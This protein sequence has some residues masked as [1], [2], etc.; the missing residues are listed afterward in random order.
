MPTVQYPPEVIQA[1]NYITA[2]DHTVGAGLKG[3]VDQ[4]LSSNKDKP[5]NSLWS[6]PVSINAYNFFLTLAKQ[7]YPAQAKTIE[8]F[9]NK[10]KKPAELQKP[11]P[12]V[13]QDI[14]NAM[15]PLAGLFQ[16]NI[17]LRVAEVGI[18][19]LLVAVGIAKLTNAVGIANKVA[20]AVGKLPIPI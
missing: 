4:W 10:T 9:V 13:A 20:G 15:N 2:H 1:F 5:S 18:G 17:W 11:S 3:A 19:I 14:K 6:D 12:Q 16:A 7:K 8:D